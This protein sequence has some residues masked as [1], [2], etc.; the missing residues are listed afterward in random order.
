MKVA[1]VHDWL[2]TYRGGEK[3]LE[4]MLEL[5]PDAPVFTLFYDKDQMP[6]SIAERT[7]YYPKWLNRFKRLRKLWL[8][9]Y[10]SIIESLPLEDYDLIISTSSCVAKG[11]IPGPRSKHLCYIH[12]PMRYIW[13]QRSYYLK[14]LARFP[15][16]S[17]IIHTLSTRLRMW[18]TLSSHR[19][20]QFISN[21]QFVK[22]R[23]HKY[24]GRGS[25][26]IPPPVDVERFQAKGMAAPIK[27]PYFL[28]AGA[29]VSYKRFDL[30]IEACEAAGLTLVVAGSGPDEARLRKLAG[31]NTKFM[32]KP[33]QQTWQSLMSQAEALIFPGI[34]DFGI[35]GIE[36]ISAGT[37]LI[38]FRDGGALDFVQP[39][40]TGQF[41]EQLSKE[42]LQQTLEA[43]D[44]KQFDSKAMQDFASGFTKQKF[45]ERIMSQ[46]T[47]LTG[48]SS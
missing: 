7:V 2:V 9:L 47:Q 30:A 26:V 12:S 16:V 24:Y 19:V 38:A 29:F 27:S 18:D 1:F 35:V 4:A 11:A 34:E 22:E 8:P 5:F 40:V 32:I 15:F 31:P 45:Q 44:P 13:D 42:S 36:A 23:V 21:S 14:P 43:F 41:F 39:G 17:G 6:P 20:D 25:E 33:D 3:V 10:P 37:P 46:I 48:A 28:A